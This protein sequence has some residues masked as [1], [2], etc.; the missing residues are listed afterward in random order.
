MCG[1][2]LGLCQFAVHVERAMHVLSQTST[3]LC[4]L[5]SCSFF[6]PTN[7]TGRRTTW[8]TCVNTGLQRRCLM[9]CST[10]T[11]HCSAMAL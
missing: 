6:P 3:V 10:W 7:N 2:L 11:W 8:R 1:E 5:L 9:D 4:V